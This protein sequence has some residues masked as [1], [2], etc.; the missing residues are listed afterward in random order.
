MLQGKF[1][2][3]QDFPYMLLIFIGVNGNL[4]KDLSSHVKLK[5]GKGDNN[6]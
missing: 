1:V 2:F 4:R 3:G 6:N 5:L